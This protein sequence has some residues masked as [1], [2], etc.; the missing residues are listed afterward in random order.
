MCNILDFKQASIGGGHELEK[1][2]EN[3][4]YDVKIWNLD[5]KSIPICDRVI[6]YSFTRPFQVSFN[7]S[8]LNYLGDNQF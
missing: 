8:F 2:K 3:L 7:S 4:K 6:K 5:R 1:R